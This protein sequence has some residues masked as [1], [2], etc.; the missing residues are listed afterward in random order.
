[1]FVGG[2]GFTSL[3]FVCIFSLVVPS[4]VVSNRAIDG[5]ENLFSKVTCYVSSATLN[6]TL[7]LSKLCYL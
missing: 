7:Y 6:S 4:L 3:G 1:M 5:L 2:L